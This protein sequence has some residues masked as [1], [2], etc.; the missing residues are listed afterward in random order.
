MKTMMHLNNIIDFGDNKDAWRA[1]MFA[2]NR[3]T[4]VI[5][6]GVMTGQQFK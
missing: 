5:F 3:T 2:T 6:E 4:F 1:S